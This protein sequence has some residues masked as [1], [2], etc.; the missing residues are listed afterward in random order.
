MDGS[1]ELITQ[2]GEF[3]ENISRTIQITI[4]T[5]SAGAFEEPFQWILTLKGGTTA[6]SS[7]T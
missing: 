6:D 2:W 3:G 1:P 4:D 7:P 5:V